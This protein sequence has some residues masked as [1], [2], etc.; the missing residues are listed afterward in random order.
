MKEKNDKTSENYQP[1]SDEIGIR[2]DHGAMIRVSHKC[3]ERT[4]G[5]IKL[6]YPDKYQ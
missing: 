1:I 3:F 2:M 5:S 6:T 4:G